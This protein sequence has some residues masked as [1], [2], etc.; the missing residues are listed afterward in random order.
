MITQC[1]KK[2]FKLIFFYNVS[3]WTAVMLLFLV[4]IPTRV[5]W[6]VFKLGRRENRYL[7][8]RT[9]HQSLTHNLPFSF[10][11]IYEKVKKQWYKQVCMIRNHTYPSTCWVLVLNFFLFSLDVLG[12]CFRLVTKNF[13]LQSF[14]LWTCFSFIL[15]LLHVIHYLIFSQLYHITTYLA[16]L[17]YFGTMLVCHLWSVLQAAHRM[18]SF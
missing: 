17:A 6:I 8:I 1:F 3:W 4:F 12:S 15:L 11:R 5:T 2:Y 14:I 10:L 16:Y 9:E 13:F 18:D 7:S